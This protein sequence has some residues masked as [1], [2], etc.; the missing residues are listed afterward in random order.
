MNYFE[1]LAPPAPC[2]VRGRQKRILQ[3]TLPDMQQVFER[4]KTQFVFELLNHCYLEMLYCHHFGEPLLVDHRDIT[5]ASRELVLQFYKSP[6][7]QGD[8][9]ETDRM[10]KIEGNRRF[11]WYKVFTDAFI[12]ALLAD[13]KDTITMLSDYTESWFEPESLAMPV[14]PGWGRIYISVA[15]AFRSKPL[16]GQAEMEELIRKSRKPAPKLLFKAWEAARDHKQSDFEKHL[17]DSVLMH[18]KKLP[19]QMC[20]DDLIA[21]PQSVILAAARRLG[22]SLPCFEPRIMARLLTSESV[23]IK[24]N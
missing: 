16:D 19:E 7:Y 18:E 13:D 9:V 5:S 2:S 14:D 1:V 4:S 6:W 3:E 12:I 21:F 11:R 15:A 20:N 22:L 23:G 10:R 24:S 17:R 8:P